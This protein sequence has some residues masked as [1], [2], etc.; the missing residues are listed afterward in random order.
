MTKIKD[1]AAALLQFEEAASKHAEAT[2][3]GDYKTGNKCYAIIAKV[4]SFLKEQNEMQKL[5]EFLNHN[6][7]GVRIWAATYLLPILESEGLR[8]LKQIAGGTGIH[9]FTAKTTVSEWEKGNL[10]L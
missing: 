9:S 7:V 6:S 8:V 4:I 3:Q 1:T 5:S 10:K 2:E